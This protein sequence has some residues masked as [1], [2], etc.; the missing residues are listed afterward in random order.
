VLNLINVSIL[1]ISRVLRKNTLI[2]ILYI[3]FI[4][5]V[6]TTLSM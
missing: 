5:Q 4:D 2:Y 1:I 3:K 6:M